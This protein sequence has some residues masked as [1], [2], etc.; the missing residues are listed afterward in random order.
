MNLKHYEPGGVFNALSQELDRW[1]DASQSQQASRAWTPAADIEETDG[2]Y[3]VRLDVPGVSPEHIEVRVEKN[4]LTVEGERE[5]VANEAGRFTRVE[6][7][8]GKFVRQFRLPDVAADEAEA[9]PQITRPQRQPS[10]PRGPEPRRMGVDRVDHQIRHRAALLVA[11]RRID[12][13]AE[14]AGDVV[15]CR[16]GPLYTV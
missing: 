11:Q 4:V 5:A 2:H 3:L 14:Q 15:S 6:R 12:V 9:P 16:G 13:L 8:Q 7:I 1:M 10:D